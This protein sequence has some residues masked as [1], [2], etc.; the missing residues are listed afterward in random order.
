MITI[1]SELPVL[2]FGNFLYNAFNE[3]ATRFV[4][5]GASL[6]LDPVQNNIDSYNAVTDLVS[7]IMEVGSAIF[8]FSANLGSLNVL[9]GL[10]FTVLISGIIVSIVLRII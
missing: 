10:G 8:D 4:P 9:I 3:Y 5:E 7:N 2:K 1:G 6:D